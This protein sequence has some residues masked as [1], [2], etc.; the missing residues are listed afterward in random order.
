MLGCTYE[1]NRTPFG[2]PGPPGPPGPPGLSLFTT[3]GTLT[4]DRTVDCAGFKL[5]MTNWD[6]FQYESSFEGNF[7]LKQSGNAGPDYTSAFWTTIGTQIDT[8]AKWS[9]EGRVLANAPRVQ[10]STHV[11]GAD[12]AFTVFG[13]LITFSSQEIQ[14]TVPPGD[15][16]VTLSP[17]YIA[18][19]APEIG[20]FGV[21]PVAQQ[22]DPSFASDANNPTSTQAQANALM[23]A[24]IALGLIRPPP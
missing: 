13:H 6:A 7:H 9:I 1:I 16:M 2:Q 11:P 12:S 4:D 24:L 20:F 14:M 8:G 19:K 18:L 10:I 21:T 15:T 17:T 22:T 5:T 3:D 23:H